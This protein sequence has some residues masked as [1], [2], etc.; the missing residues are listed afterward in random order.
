MELAISKYQDL[1]FGTSRY[2]AGHGSSLEV[3]TPNI[4]RCQLR[5]ISQLLRQFPINLFKLVI[6]IANISV[7]LPSAQVIPAVAVQQS[8]DDIDGIPEFS[9]SQSVA[10]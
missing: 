8:V 1:Q 10:A 7:T 9:I 3:T 4:Q 2:A 6:A 5:N